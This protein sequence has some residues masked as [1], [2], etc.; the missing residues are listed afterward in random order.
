MGINLIAEIGINHD[1]DYQ[2]A[3]S[4]IKA[5]FESGAGSPRIQYSR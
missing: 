1:G 5:A 4:L 3:I 2:K